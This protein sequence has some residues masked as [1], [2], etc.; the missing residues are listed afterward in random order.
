MSHSRTVALLGL[1]LAALILHATCGGN[2]STPT[3]PPPTA[4]T[5]L[6]ISGN[7]VLKSTGQTS[8]LIATAILADGRLDLVTSRTRWSSGDESIVT[9]SNSGLVSATGYGRTVIQ[10]DYAQQSV[11]LDFTVLPEGTFI[12]SGVVS[13][14]GGLPIE[15]AQISLSGGTVTGPRST[16]ANDVGFYRFSGVAGTIAVSAT[17][18]GYV[19]QEQTV[20]VSRDVEVDFQLKQTNP[21]AN[22]GGSYKL[23]I[24]AAASCSSQLPATARSRTYHAEISQDGARLRV[25]LSGANFI[26][27]GGGYY[28]PSTSNSFNGR[29]LG[30][31]I[32]FDLRAGGGYFYGDHFH[33]AE[34]LDNRFLTVSGTAE[35]SVSGP[36]ISG[37]LVGEIDIFDS[38]PDLGR[39]AIVCPADDHR[40]TFAK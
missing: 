34:A 24:A 1:G 22:V 26:E 27:T 9:V 19:R 17:H 20:S 3:G 30:N 15:G 29:A 37:V 39:P 2:P 18:P 7:L 38:H 23:T 5:A 13:E 28:G 36:K 14:G 33:I 16:T 12:M 4:V 6:Q 11:T 25:V 31:R 8:Q 32:T 35:T 40:F 21:P 10:A